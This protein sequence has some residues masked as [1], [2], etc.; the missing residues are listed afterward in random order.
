MFHSRLPAGFAH[1]VL[2]RH[3]VH[4]GHGFQV[5]L[6]GLSVAHSQDR[7]LDQ[8]RAVHRCWKHLWIIEEF[9]K[10]GPPAGQQTIDSRPRSLSKASVHTPVDW[11]SDGGTRP[12]RVNVKMI[13]TFALRLHDC[14]F[15]AKPSNGDR[16]K[17]CS[18]GNRQAEMHAAADIHDHR[19]GWN[20]SQMTVELRVKRALQVCMWFLSQ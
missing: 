2:Q 8:P 13:A 20:C 17:A 14:D 16:L 12:Y 6:A 9:R 10:N 19:P 18:S 11:D 15:M 7:S 1:L 4:V 3:R 5:V